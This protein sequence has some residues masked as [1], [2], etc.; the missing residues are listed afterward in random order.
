MWSGR[1]CLIQE[2]HLGLFLLGCYWSQRSGSDSAGAGC[3]L[4]KRVGLYWGGEGG[5]LKVYL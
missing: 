1:F 4:S 3:V 5:R 2:F